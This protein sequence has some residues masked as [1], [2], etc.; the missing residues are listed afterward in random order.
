MTLN[1][2]PLSDIHR[3]YLMQTST[4]VPKKY[5]VN[6]REYISEPNHQTQLPMKLEEGTEEYEIEQGFVILS[7]RKDNAKN[8]F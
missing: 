8:S 7:A 5:V 2:N 6:L 4:T 1:S 3:I